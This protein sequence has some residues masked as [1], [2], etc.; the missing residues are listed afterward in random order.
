VRKQEFLFHR[1]FQEFVFNGLLDPELTFYSDEVWFTLS[2]Y[3]NSNN[4]YQNT[5]NPHS[6]HDVPMHDLKL[7]FGVHFAWR[8]TEPM[9]LSLDDKF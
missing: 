1:W 9:F 6:V 7:G 3:V 8:I 5:E 2:S 4:R